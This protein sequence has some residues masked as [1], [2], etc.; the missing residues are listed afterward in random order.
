[1]KTS[2]F[3]IVFFICA[4]ACTNK[5]ADIELTGLNSET[6]VFSVLKDDTYLPHRVDDALPGNYHPFM[7]YLVPADYEIGISSHIDE[8]MFGKRTISCIS[9]LS[10]IQSI[11]TRSTNFE[12]PQIVSFIDGTEISQE[13]LSRARTRAVNNAFMDAFGK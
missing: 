1:M 9:G 12:L 5:E 2:H 4:I 8:G 11:R 13:S 6:L 3:T 10:E 7:K